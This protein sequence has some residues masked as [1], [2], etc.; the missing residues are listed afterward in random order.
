MALRLMNTKP[1]FLSSG[2]FVQ[3]QVSAVRA[4]LAGFRYDAVR[5]CRRPMMRIMA[6]A[7][8]WLY[9]AAYLIDWSI[10]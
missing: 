10:P 2:I 9:T 8:N 1:Y 4:A 5:H 7:C 6:P 3:P